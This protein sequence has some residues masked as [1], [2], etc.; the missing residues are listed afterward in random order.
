MQKEICLLRAWIST[1]GEVWNRHG[2]T[3]MESGDA[4][5]LRMFEKVSSF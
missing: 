1:F 5:K 4:S 3:S 2:S